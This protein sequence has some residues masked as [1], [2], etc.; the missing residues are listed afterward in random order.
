MPVQAERRKKERRD[1]GANYFWNT[2]GANDLHR[3]GTA[4]SNYAVRLNLT[5]ELAT[6]VPLAN[7]ND[8]YPPATMADPDPLLRRLDLALTGG[9]LSAKQFQ[10]IR[11]KW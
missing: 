7:I 10:I 6:F 8:N 1:S 5:N 3:W 11:R 4:N 2:I 9:T